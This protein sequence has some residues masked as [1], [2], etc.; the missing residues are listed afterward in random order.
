M[1]DFSP[2]YYRIPAPTWLFRISSSQRHGSGGKTTF[3][4]STTRRWNSTDCGSI[5]MNRQV[6]STASGVK[7]VRLE[8]HTTTHHTYQVS[9]VCD[10]NRQELPLELKFFDIT[11]FTQSFQIKC[12]WFCCYDVRVAGS[13]RNVQASWTVGWNLYKRAD[14]LICFLFVCFEFKWMHLLVHQLQTTR[15]SCVFAT[16]LVGEQL[17]TKT[18]CMSSSQYSSTSPENKELHYN[19]HSLYGWSQAEPTMM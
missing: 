17:F 10:F 8:T 11:P 5:W 16:D 12:Y 3:S 1:S 6:L 7:D 18:M 4:G 9:G 13:P 15:F 19:I 2:N 14:F